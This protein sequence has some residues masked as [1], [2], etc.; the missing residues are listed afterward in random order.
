MRLHPVILA[1]GSGTRF[2]PLS[3]RRRPKQLLA[4]ASNLPLIAETAARLEGLCDTADILTVCGRA[5]AHSIR[6]LLPRV[7]SKGILVEPVARNTA[8]AIGLA[9]LVVR[10]RDPN[11]VLA[12]L[13]SDHAILNRQ[14]FHDA[15]RDA[16][17]TASQG[18]LVTIGIRPTRPETGFGY[19][20]VG[21][22]HPK[23]ARKVLSFVEKP[24]LAKAQ[25]YLHS[26]DYLWN[27]GMFVFRADRMLEEL[28]THAPDCAAALA[29][30][31]PFVG[32]QGFARALARWFPECPSVSIDY[33]VMEKAEDLAVVPA[34]LG[35]SDLGSF[36]SLPDVRKADGTGNV[37]D[38]D[39]LFFD[40]SRNVVIGQR[41]KPIAL[42]GCSD[43]VVIDAGDAV[44]VCSRERAQEVR[45]VVEALEARGDERLL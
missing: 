17:R 32:T 22:T 14:A 18:P 2:W 4:L 6:R 8:A 20:K 15:V 19:I 37:V 35:W 45:R 5:H 16:A 42:I 7:A 44:L 34:E 9:S 38:G 31:E 26:G 28:Q 13:P 10:A 23:G 36:A 12:V 3:R 1:G 40:A 25:S 29:K 30:I 33:A 41:T 27:A 11:G 39:V 43:L 21:E 24:D